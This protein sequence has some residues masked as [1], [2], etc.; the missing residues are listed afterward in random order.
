MTTP[1]RSLPAPARRGL[2]AQ[3]LFGKP[4]VAAAEKHRYHCGVCRVTYG[5]VGS[6]GELYALR[7]WHRGDKH[8]GGTPDGEKI[9]SPPPPP[10]FAKLRAAGAMFK[11]TFVAVGIVCMVIIVI[12][13]W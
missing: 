9:I 7:T 1:R 3:L 2:L 5:P 13:G 8:G 6:K 11:R 12:V 4:V 10:P